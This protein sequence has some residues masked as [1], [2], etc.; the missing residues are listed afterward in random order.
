MVS[1]L[2]RETE[3]DIGEYKNYLPGH[4]FGQIYSPFWTYSPNNG[5]P[6]NGFLNSPSPLSFYINYSFTNSFHRF[7]GSNS[8]P[9]N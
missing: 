5:T 7:T 8:Y 3:E 1:S 9:T 2:V 6:N 4:E